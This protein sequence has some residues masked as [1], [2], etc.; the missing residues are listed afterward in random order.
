MQLSSCI[1]RLLIP[2]MIIVGSCGAGRAIAQIDEPAH[3]YFLT[4]PTADWFLNLEPPPPADGRIL[5]AGCGGTVCLFVLG[6]DTNEASSNLAALIVDEVEGCDPE[7]VTCCDLQ[8]HTRVTDAEF[9]GPDAEFKGQRFWLSLGE[10]CELS[11]P[12]VGRTDDDSSNAEP[13]I[14]FIPV[15]AQ[16]WQDMRSRGVTEDSMT[17]AT[18]NRELRVLVSP[19]WKASELLPRGPAPRI[20]SQI[21]LA[22]H[23]AAFVT[24]SGCFTAD[25][26]KSENGARCYTERRHWYVKNDAGIWCEQTRKCKCPP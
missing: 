24:A 13:G 12:Q 14:P 11:D 9:K 5:V 6:S 19:S 21:I 3:A 22:N 17:L 20:G 23:V 25:Y 7:G 18:A 15:E 1:S 8:T 10:Y 2:M 16:I 26:C 4:G